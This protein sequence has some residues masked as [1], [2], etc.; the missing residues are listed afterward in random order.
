MVRLSIITGGL[1]TN[2]TSSNPIYTIESEIKWLPINNNP[3]QNIGN[4]HPD[5]RKGKIRVAELL[6][7]NGFTVEYEHPWPY[8]YEVTYFTD[9][10]MPDQHICVEIDGRSHEGKIN[11]WRD[12][13][14]DEFINGKGNQTIRVK[15][16][17][18]LDYP[19]YALNLVTDLLESSWSKNLRKRRDVVPELTSLVYWPGLKVES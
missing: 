16:A 14:K 4:E 6:S 13:M 12:A 9:I 3:D 18:A 10:Y 5:H 19:E 15:L 2:V 1:L 7:K 17:D 11:K 8:N